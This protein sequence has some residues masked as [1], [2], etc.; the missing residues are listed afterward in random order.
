MFERDEADLMRNSQNASSQ[1][2]VD[3]INNELEGLRA[4]HAINLRTKDSKINVVWTKHL[5]EQQTRLVKEGI[6]GFAVTDDPALIKAQM[7]LIEN[8]LSLPVS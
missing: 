7:D 3:L 6:P 5:K 4:T 2:E 8:L 1:E